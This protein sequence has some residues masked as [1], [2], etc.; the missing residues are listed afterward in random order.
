[1][2]HV[3]QITPGEYWARPAAFDWA[4]SPFM[5]GVLKVFALFRRSE[6]WVQSQ[7]APQKIAAALGR[8]GR[9][10]TMVEDVGPGERNPLYRSRF[11]QVY[12]CGR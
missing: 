8:A 4:N 11:S 6:D 7:I 5:S 1:M 10:D 12:A 2:R 9:R 3:I